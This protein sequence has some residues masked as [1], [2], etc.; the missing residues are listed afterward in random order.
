M[1]LKGCQNSAI[2]LNNIQCNIEDEKQKH[3]QTNK[4]APNRQNL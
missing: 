1:S 2:D 4:K 3:K